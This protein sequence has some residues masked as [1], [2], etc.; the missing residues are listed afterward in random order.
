MLRLRSLGTVQLHCVIAPA[1]TQDVTAILPICRNQALGHDG[2]PVH[3][4][5]GTEQALASTIVVGLEP[6]LNQYATRLARDSG[7]GIN[8]R[9][10]WPDYP[11]YAAKLTKFEYH[12]GMLGAH[13]VWCLSAD[14]ITR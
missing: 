3:V 4:T 14:G 8:R 13:R 5:R 7:S 9:D 10:I 1:N 12:S 2:K 11:L 6:P